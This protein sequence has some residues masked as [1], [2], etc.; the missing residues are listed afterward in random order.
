MTESQHT[1]SSEFL[2]RLTALAADKL[3]AQ[4]A[5][6]AVR[7]LRRYFARVPMEVLEEREPL[8]L[9]GAAI[10]HLSLAQRRRFG[11][12]LVRVYNPVLEE[13]GWES[14]HTVVEI[15]TDDMPFLV[16]SVRMAANRRGLEVLLVVHPIYTMLR[17]PGGELLDVRE[18]NGGEDGVREAVMHLEMVRRTEAA[19]LRELRRELENTLV[20]VRSAV[21]DWSAMRDTMDGVVRELENAPP[22]VDRENLDESLAFLRWILDHHFTFLGYRQ[23]QLGG[24]NGDEALQIV[25]DSGLGILRQT[26]EDLRSQAF[27]GL[28]PKLRRLAKQQRLLILIKANAQATVHRPA[29]LDY[30]GI[31]RFD[32]EGRVLGEYRFLGLYGSRAY[33]GTPQDIPILRRKIEQVMGQADLEPNS[34]YAKA[35]LHILETYPRDELF[36]IETDDLYRIAMGILQLGERQRPRLFVRVDPYGRFVVCMV[37]AL[38]ERYDTR[39]RQRMQRILADAFDGSEVGFS[40]SLTE[41]P[42]AR[43]QFTVRTRPGRIPAFDERDIEARLADA[44]LSWS[45]HLHSALLEHMG[46]ARGSVLYQAYQDAFPAGY[47][48]DFPA[49]SAVRDIELMSALSEHNE[50]AMS[51]YRPVEATPGQLRFKVFRYRCALP[52]SLALPMLEH[53]GVQ[54]EDERPYCV[55]HPQAPLWVHDFGLTH[56]LADAPETAEIRQPFQEVFAGAW[57]GRLASDGFNALVLRARLQGR[58]IGLLRAYAKYLRQ[59]G[60]TFSQEYMEEAVVSHPEVARLLVELFEARFDPQRPKQAQQKVARL[61]ERIQESL[62]AVQSLDHDRILRSFLSLVQ[63]TLRTNYYQLDQHGQPKPSIALKLEPARIPDLPEP[64]PQFEIFVYAPRVEGVHLRGGQVARGGLRWS[65]RKEDY[66]TEILGLMKAQLVKNAVIVPVGAKGGFVVKTPPTEGGREALRAE[67]EACYRIFIAGLLDL[68]D[69]LDDEGC[70]PP[71]RLVRYD[72][73]DPYLVVAADKGTATFSDIANEVAAGY[74]FWLGDAFASGGR[75]GYDHKKMGITARGAWESVR[76]HFRAAGIDYD[77]QSFTVAGIGDMSGDVFGNGLLWSRNSR[78]LA[79]FDHRHIFLDPSPDPEASFLERQRLFALPGSSW[80]DYDAKLISEG[81]GVYP[82]SLKSVRLS[83][84]ARGALG[85][86]AESLTPANLISAI[87]KAPVDL[88]WNGGIGTYVKA[89]WERHADVGDRVNDV[90]RVD[91]RNLRCRVVGEGGNLGLTQAARIEYALGGGRLDTDSVHNAGGVNCSDHEVNI[92]ILLDRVVADGDMT[93]KQRDRLLEEMTEE[94][95]ELVLRD[96][97]WQSFAIGLDQFGS[98]SLWPEQVR[99]LRQLEQAGQLDRALEFLPDD[100]TLARR[101]S[102]AIGMTRPELALLHS[103][104]KHTFYQAL[105]ESDLPDDPCMRPELQRYFPRP[106]RERFSG[107]IDTHKL[108]REILA[109]IVSN[110]LINRFGA[111]FAFR[112]EEELGASAAAVARAYA[113]VWDVFELRRLWSGVAALDG[114]V[115]E[116]V[117]LECIA[118]ARQLAARACRWLLQ[119]HGEKIQ[120]SSLIELYRQPVAAIAERLPA[121]LEELHPSPGE[122]TEPPARPAVPDVLARWVGSFDCLFSALDIVDVAQRAHTDPVDTAQVYFSLGMDLELDWLVQRITGLGSQDRWHAE[123]RAGLRDDLYAR[124]RELCAAVLGGA[125]AGTSALSKVEAWRHQNHG[126]VERYR[127]ML[128]ELRAQ[129]KVDMAMLSVVLREVRR[130]AASAAAELASGGPVEV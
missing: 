72:G 87:L 91:A 106:I 26:P 107:R 75:A 29:N 59:T 89:S 64:R 84:E 104:A 22:P 42:L 68:T 63:A 9:Y 130:L 115:E 117:R 48:E 93:G 3:P 71:P 116:V 54:V 15:V 5:P 101:Q 80:A 14:P 124:Q 56:E 118:A 6:R 17:G 94:V 32:A 28:P 110:R 18:R 8:D 50:L 125:M 24:V 57:S 27:A 92:K 52:L 55:E 83:P 114:V 1:L 12:T 123:A 37:Y 128:G 95:A 67:V 44:I 77:N 120:I 85:I 121:L 40:V 36:Q 90:L 51:L 23:Y 41:S 79:A 19:D 38:R 88:L 61:T 66:R 46:E 65:D 111:T 47:R 86:S 99:L 33:G 97:Y 113:V 81:G 70:R 60:L 53:M 21:E 108:R 58:Q 109:T 43:I 16:D 31:R 96:C 126:A 10:A 127:R 20:D 39:V 34:H 30:I 7:F 82:R 78:L 129:D 45:D 25:P 98:T 105:L 4:S 35:L 62:D 74:G 100:E 73:D 102:Q 122:E 49:R 13:H 103:Y 76:L 119:R 112:L 69:N 2:E 11:Q